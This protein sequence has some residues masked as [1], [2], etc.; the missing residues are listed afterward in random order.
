[1]IEQVADG[2]TRVAGSATN[3]YVVREGDALT[4]VDSGY[5]GDWRRVVGALDRMQRTPADVEAVVLTHAH[6]DHIGSA[7]RLRTQHDAVVHAHAAEAPM[8]RGERRER[9]STAFMVTRLWWPKMLRFL[10]KVVAAGGVTEDHV[11]EV[12]E[13]AA[14]G[15]LDVPGRPVPVFTPG[16]TSGH[17]AFYFPDRGALLTGDGLVTYD[18]L[19]RET[20]P[21]LLHRAFNHDQAGALRSLDELA[22]LAADV[23]LPGHGEPFRG[24]PAAAV[25][26]A[27]DLSS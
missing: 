9:I 15:P 12:T 24:S 26:Q 11:G 3:F 8:A 5:P 17:C 20:G 22:D 18:V 7:E 13:F 21:R 25:A 23:V 16:H 19:T 6:V 10:A 1:M 2:I 14:G 27:R 4:L